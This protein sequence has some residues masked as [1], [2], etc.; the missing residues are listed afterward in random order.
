M[1]DRAGLRRHFEV[2]VAAEDVARCK[3]D[4]EGYQAALA[5]LSARRPLAVS[6]SVAIEDS[7]PGLAAARA[8]GLRCTM[9]STSH[10]PA[11][12]SEADAVWHSFTGHEPAELFVW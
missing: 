11:T 12:L 10:D 5:A 8:A 3:P 2:V 7:L 6:R 1:L 9:L 4:P